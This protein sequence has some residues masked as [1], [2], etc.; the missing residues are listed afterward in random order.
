MF[1]DIKRLIQCVTDLFD[2]G[3]NCV[4]NI[5]T[6]IFFFIIVVYL[7]HYCTTIL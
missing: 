1:E 6:L 4:L 7:I 3:N 2:K 5:F